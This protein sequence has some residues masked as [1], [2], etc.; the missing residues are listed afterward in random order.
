[1]TAGARPAAGLAPGA[2]VIA[3]LQAPRDRYWGVLRSIDTAGIVIEGIDLQAFDD[4]T[5]QV[6][7]GREGLGPSTVFFP[8]ARVEKILLDAPA[9]GVPALQDQF[10]TRT[11]RTLHEALEP[12]GPAA[13]T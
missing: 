12:G 1:V 4:W 7:E 6:A 13:E 5:R 10:E 11:G 3:Y 9:G 2:V 8:L